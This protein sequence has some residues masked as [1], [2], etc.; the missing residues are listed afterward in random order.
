MADEE[1]GFTTTENFPRSVLLAEA[2]ELVNLEAKNVSDEG[3]RE[4]V[5]PHKKAAAETLSRL[6]KE[7][8]EFSPRLDTREIGLAEFE[9]RGIRPRRTLTAKLQT[10]RLYEIQVPVTLFPRSGWAF[11]RLECWLEFAPGEDA[12]L[13]PTVHDLFPEDKWQVQLKA[14]AAVSIGIDEEARFGASVNASAG[15][16]AVNA[17]VG[18]NAVF[19]IGPIE[20]TLRRST[21]RARGRGNVECFWRL[22]GTDCVDG[23]D[24]QLGVILAVPIAR[25]GPVPVRGELKAYHDFNV[26]TAD[27]F[28][29]WVHDFSDALKSLAGAG[30]VVTDRQRW[31]LPME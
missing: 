30:F 24:I 12:A 3:Q 6:G 2:L 25:T 16:A 9:E 8:A 28:T 21:I 29:D 26:L 5:Q 1:L 22:D 10:H 18:G 23:E 19:V 27:I 14:S 7:Q 15:R 17:Q 13:R 31:L 20:R 4:H 11:S